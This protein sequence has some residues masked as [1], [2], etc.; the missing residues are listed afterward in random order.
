MTEQTKTHSTSRADAL[1]GLAHVFVRG[2]KVEAVVGIHEH[3][4]VGPQPLIISIDLT[5]QE[6]AASHDDSI[7]SVVCYEKVV[8]GVQAICGMGHV[9][10]I[11][12]LAEKIAAHCLT[13][14]RVHAVRVLVEKPQAFSECAS[15]GVE[16][17]R[18]QTFS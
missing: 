3:E 5:A 2:L 11:E 4:K 6:S 7:H 1:H 17:E 14:K 12:T 13:D 9:N 10:L 15:V 18:L 16:I 8:R